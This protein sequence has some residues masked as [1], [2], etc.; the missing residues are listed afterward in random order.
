MVILNIATKLWHFKRQLEHI[1]ITKNYPYNCKKRN[2]FPSWQYS[3]KKVQLQIVELHTY[4]LLDKIASIKYIWMQNQNSKDF[5]LI[6]DTE[7]SL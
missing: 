4:I 1:A 2:I 7:T 5:L 3:P 6:I